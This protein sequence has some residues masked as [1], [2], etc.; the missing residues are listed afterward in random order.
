MAAYGSMLLI[1]AEEI[2]RRLD[3]TGCLVLA[4]TFFTATAFGQATNVFAPAEFRDWPQITE[5]EKQMRAPLVQKDAGAEVLVWKAYVVD[6]F[7]SLSTLQRV[8]YNYVRLKVFDEKGKEQAATVDLT[9]TET[10]S[11]IDISGRTMK[12][13]G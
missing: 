8:Y 5:A 12:P 13:D 10:S 3:V 6:E 4:T 9:S 7:L 11:I 2:M 1:S